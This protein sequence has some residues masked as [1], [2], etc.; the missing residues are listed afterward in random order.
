VQAADG[1]GTAERL[2]DSPNPQQPQSITADGSGLIIREGRDKNG[3]DLF[4]LSLGAPRTERAL[5]STPAAE[6]SAELSPNGRWLA[7]Q[8]GDSGPS[9]VFVR[10]FPEVNAGLFQVSRG[11][12]RMPLWSRDGRELFYVTPAN[13][14]MRVVIEPGNSFRFGSPETVLD[15]RYFFPGGTNS[16][17]FDIS[18]DGQRFL[19]IKPVVKSTSEDATSATLV[20]VQ[21]WFEELKRLVH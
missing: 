3:F 8:S 16:R 21:N 4:L 17:T 2:V 5:V 1:T 15:G 20:V 6:V 19:M 14:L 18:R 13:V 10:P 11:G 9:D 7:Y 12:G